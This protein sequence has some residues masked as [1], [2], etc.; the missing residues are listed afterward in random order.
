MEKYSIPPIEASYV[1]CMVIRDSKW[2]MPASKPRTSHAIQCLGCEGLG[3]A[4]PASTPTSHAMPYMD[5]ASLRTNL[6]IFFN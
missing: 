4:R 3:P 1:G 5:Q 6:F 2:A